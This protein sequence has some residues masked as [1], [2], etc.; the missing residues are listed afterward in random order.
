MPYAAC[1]SCAFLVKINE[2]HIPKKKVHIKS[3]KKQHTTWGSNAMDKKVT[4]LFKK[5]IR[6][7]IISFLESLWCVQAYKL[8]I[9]Y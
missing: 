5:I 8:V 2:V 7:F 4:E 6:T 9:I 3:L 1:L